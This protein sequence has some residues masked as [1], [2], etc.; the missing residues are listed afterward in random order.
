MDYLI[1]VGVEKYQDSNFSKTIYANNDAEEFCNVLKRHLKINKSKALLDEN[2]SYMSVQMAINDFM[3]QAEANDRLFFYFAGHGKNFY[4]EPRI[5][6]YD[7]DSN[8]GKHPES[9]YDLKK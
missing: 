5:A 1:S 4:N 9:W 3:E 8:I 6:C 7:S 2:A